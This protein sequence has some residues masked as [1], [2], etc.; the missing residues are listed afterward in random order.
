MSKI[1]I[2][3]LRADTFDNRYINVSG[4]SMT[5]VLTT[6]GLRKSVAVKTFDYTLLTTDEVVVFTETATANLPPATGS[7]QTYKICNEGNGTVTIDP[8]NSE[9]ILGQNNKTLSQNE[10]ITITDYDVGKWA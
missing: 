2:L 4:D 10:S 5:G 9:T 1:K 3:K 7:G 8:Y 6:N